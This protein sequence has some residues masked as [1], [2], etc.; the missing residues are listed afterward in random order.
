MARMQTNVQELLQKEISRKEFLTIAGLGV[1][2]V[3]GF[4]PLVKFLTGK[5]LARQQLDDDYGSSAYGGT[6][7]KGSIFSG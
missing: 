2:S 6:K 4:E 1:L 5:S 3:F 7:E